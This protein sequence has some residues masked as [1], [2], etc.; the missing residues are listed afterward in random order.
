[1]K[2]YDSTAN[3]EDGS[4]IGFVIF[5]YFF[6]FSQKYGCTDSNAFN[7]DSNANTDQGCI[8]KVFGC[9]DNKAKNF[10]NTANVATND[11]CLYTCD[12]D[13]VLASEDVIL[14][15]ECGYTGDKMVVKSTNSCMEWSPNSIHVPR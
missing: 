13:E 10:D 14:C 15:S 7:Y 4:C 2:N 3:I 1:M 5:F 9:M 11:E 6:I 8:P 12:K